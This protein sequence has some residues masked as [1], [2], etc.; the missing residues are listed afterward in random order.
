MSKEGKNRKPDNVKEVLIAILIGACVSF[1]TALFDGLADFL[2]ANSQQ[3]V[4]AMSSFAY[5][6]AKRYHV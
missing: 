5:Y 1:L 6:V 3:I 2:R 4:A